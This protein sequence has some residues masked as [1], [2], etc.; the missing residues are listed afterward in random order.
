MQKESIKT[1][2][3][4]TVITTILFL[5]V[6]G[7]AYYYN[8]T[9]DNKTPFLLDKNLLARALKGVDEK[10]TYKL[11]DHHLGFAKKVD[12]ENEQWLQKNGYR[13]R[14]GFIIYSA[15]PDDKL[16]RPIILTLGGSTTDGL[17]YGHSWPEDLSKLFLANGVPGTIINGGTGGYSSNQE[18][19]KLLRDGLSLKPD[20]VISYS[21]VNDRGKYSELPYPMV[22]IYQK[23]VLENKHQNKSIIFP[24]TIELFS[25]FF[26]GALA[27]DGGYTFG[28][29]SN[30]TL[31][32][33]YIRNMQIMNALS[34]LYGIKFFGVLQP[35]A[36]CRSEDVWSGGKAEKYKKA[37]RVLY[38]DLMPRI[39]R[40]NFMSDATQLFAGEKD[41]YK[42]DGVH[43]LPRGDKLVAQYMFEKIRTESKRPDPD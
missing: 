15:L 26:G 19:L 13:W 21:G 17:K 4:V 28:I 34:E 32:E 43:L 12:E 2:F 3:S 30:L 37:I 33:Q 35:C 14:S 31:W 11:L 22:H 9:H 10:D 16:E 39:K 7:A 41:V 20:I 36:F 42:S 38:D 5:A 1:I 6:E 27:S 18:L 8:F 25:R 29:E 40:Y 24:S 23:N